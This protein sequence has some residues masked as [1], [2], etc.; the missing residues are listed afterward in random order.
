MEELEIGSEITLKVIEDE[1]GECNGCFFNDLASYIYED[2]CK[3]IKCGASQRK[4]R[5][6]VIFVRVEE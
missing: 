2:P 4:D 5:K 1:K 3:R 6:N